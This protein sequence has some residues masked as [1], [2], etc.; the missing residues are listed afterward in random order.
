[1]NARHLEKWRE[2]ASKSPSPGMK[3]L[4]RQYPTNTNKWV[5]TLKTVNDGAHDTRRWAGREAHDTWTLENRFNFSCARPYVKYTFTQDQKKSNF[6]WKMSCWYILEGTVYIWK[7]CCPKVIE[8]IYSFFCSFLILCL[9]EKLWSVIFFC[10]PF[11]VCL[12]IVN[13]K[14]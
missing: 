4:K 14:H 6:F 12:F 8:F 13:Q 10:T 7:M 3:E 11:H 1:M 2:S 5:L 9:S